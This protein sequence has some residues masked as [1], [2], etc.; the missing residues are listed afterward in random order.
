MNIPCIVLSLKN[1]GI[2][3]LFL[4]GNLICTACMGPLLLGVSTKLKPYYDSIA[5][6]TSSILGLFFAALWGCLNQHSFKKGLK[7]IFY[8]SYAWESFTLA[9]CVSTLAVLI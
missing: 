3:N 6:I 5:L 1:F 8:D 9:L 7:L 2:V 4:S